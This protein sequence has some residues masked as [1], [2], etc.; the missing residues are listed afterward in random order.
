MRAHYHS[1]LPGDLSLPDVD[2]CATPR[3]VSHETLQTL[4]YQLYPKQHSS[5]SLEEQ[6]RT[7][8]KELGFPWEGEVLRFDVPAT[9]TVDAMKEMLG[10]YT[11]ERV[12]EP[13]DILWMFTRGHAYLDIEE[14][15]TNS[16]IRLSLD[17][18][19]SILI[20]AG[21]YHHYTLS[22]GLGTE[23]RMWAMYKT[24]DTSYLE[25]DLPPLIFGQEAEQH[26]VRRAYLDSIRL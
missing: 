23:L 25:A 11:K 9:E 15:W 24:S 20:P 18:G 8:S 21:A 16:T 19:E 1:K 7:I 3:P 13:Y 4:K 14:P 22:T 5:R 6:F 2:G 10:Y 26:P 12:I 17:E